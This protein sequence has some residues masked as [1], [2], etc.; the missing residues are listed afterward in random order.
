MLDFFKLFSSNKSFSKDD[1]KNRLK[2][3]L[4]NDRNNFPPALLESIQ[5]EMIAVVRKYMEVDE[6]NIEIK[7]IRS[8][9]TEEREAVS[10]LVANIPVRRIK[11]DP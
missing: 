5:K 7:M 4:I 10:E 1:A 9:N 8:K 3:V 6:E 11:Q 2:L